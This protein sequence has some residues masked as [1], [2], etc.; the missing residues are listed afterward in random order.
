MEQVN[1]ADKWVQP[2]HLHKTSN[3]GLNVDVHTDITLQTIS[4]CEF[5][6]EKNKTSAR[7]KQPIAMCIQHVGPPRLSW[8]KEGDTNFA[9]AILP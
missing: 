7:K 2:I 9:C 8:Q 5:C 4:L 1:F 3:L 6:L